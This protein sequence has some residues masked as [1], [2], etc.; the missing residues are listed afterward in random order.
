MTWDN[1]SIPTEGT[2]LQLHRFA[3]VN[4]FTQAVNEPTRGNNLS[5]HQSAIFDAITECYGPVQLE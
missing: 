5:F 2:S 3:T 1:C 4:G